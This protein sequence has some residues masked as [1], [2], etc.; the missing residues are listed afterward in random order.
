MGTGLEYDSLELAKECLVFM[1]ESMNENWKIPV[2]NFQVSSLTG[3]QKAELTKHALNLLK[4]TGISIASLTFDGYS[5]NL[6]IARLLGCDLLAN[7]LN[8]IFD[9]IAVFMDPTQADGS[10]LC[11]MLLERNENLLM[12]MVNKYVSI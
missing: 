11:G 7:N 9:N 5:S 1:V 6:T 10:S 3:A 4:G 2:G 12:G 8:S